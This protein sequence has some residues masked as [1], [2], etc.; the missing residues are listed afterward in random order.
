MRKNT[1]SSS[2]N[3]SYN[4]RQNASYNDSAITVGSAALN[5]VPL[6]WRGNYSRIIEAIIQAKKEGVKLLCLPELT[7]TGYNCDDYFHA[8]HVLRKSFEYLLK[9]AESTS[10]IAVLV[11]LPVEF[12]NRVFNCQALIADKK[13][14]GIVAKKFM[15]SDG[16]HY[17]PRFFQPW[18]VGDFT[19]YRYK[20]ADQ[21]Q[22]GEIEFE[23]P[24]GDMIFNLNGVKVAVEICQDSWV[25]D[26]PGILYSKQ[27]TDIILCPSSTHFATGK[28]DT[29]RRIVTE[30]SRVLGVCYVFCNSLGSE[31]GK[32]V[33]DGDARIA[34][35]GKILVEAQSLA[36]DDCSLVSAEINLSHNRGQ[37]LR[38]V[39][40]IFDRGEKYIE[41]VEVNFSL[42]SELIK[43]S[44]S[45]HQIKKQFKTE[46]DKTFNELFLA[47]TLGAFDYLRKSKSNGYVIS[48]SGGADSSLT[49]ILAVYSLIRAWDELGRVKF[50]QKL[51]HIKK[52]QS[53]RD[54]KTV[55]KQL[56]TTVYQSTVNN[57]KETQK[58]AEVLAKA[59]GTDHHLISV[60]KT[61]KEYT[62]E[63]S[64]RLNIKLDWKNYDIPLQNIQSRVRSPSVWMIANI[65]NSLLLTTGNRSEASV[66]YCTLD[67]DTSGGYNLVGGLS[68]ELI[69]RWLRWFAD[70]GPEKYGKLKGLE[71]VNR[72]SPSAEL[73]PLGTSQTDEK[74][75]MPYEVLQD[76]EK[77]AVQ[78]KASPLSIYQTLHKQYN[79]KSREQ[80]NLLKS[81]IKKFFQLWARNQWKR[82]RLAP[83]LHLEGYNVDPRSWMRFPILCA[84]FEEELEELEKFA[85]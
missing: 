43:N 33:Y 7:I 84:G 47:S 71:Y 22:K 24:F 27:G 57:S 85:K 32:T 75:L 14:V 16:V 17:E 30:S 77:L 63:I 13:I 66:G 18:E 62:N 70:V 53:S 69:L 3:N 4:V 6:D 8:P 54:I 74:D 40:E 68:K 11:G 31:T 46:E 38:R 60:D 52:I 50:L 19:Y 35:N 25:L 2:S 42:N 28:V 12:N 79:Y 41:E 15:A 37:Q 56:I 44:N 78:L 51:K 45:N 72:L 48:L 59:M 34:Y 29:R 76:I 49:T 36:Y 26:R 80:K 9:I 5:Q 10:K 61:V 58:S 23:I 65:K 64:Q 73:R 83:A 67:G 82:E 81:W 55:I 39:E 1:N 21:N 20:K